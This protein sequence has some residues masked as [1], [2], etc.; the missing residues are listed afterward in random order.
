[1]DEARTKRKFDE[2]LSDE[3]QDEMQLRALLGAAKRTGLMFYEVA[4]QDKEKAREHGLKNRYF[5]VTSD[6]KKAKQ[7]VRLLNGYLEKKV[8]VSGKDKSSEDN[9][10]KF[11]CLFEV[12]E[13]KL[14]ELTPDASEE[15]LKTFLLEHEKAYDLIFV[16]AQKRLSVLNKG[17]L[18]SVMKQAKESNRNEKVLGAVK[19]KLIKRLYCSQV[20]GKKVQAQIYDKEA[21]SQ[22]AVI[23]KGQ[24]QK[25]TRER[26]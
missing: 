19:N 14:Q 20:Q 12:Q 13:K 11:D 18:N 8:A 3:V 21:P 4:T 10:P 7:V 15:S 16:E 2:L 6:R 26:G 23:F 1:M 9:L 24:Q 22:N 5:F 17:I 25:R